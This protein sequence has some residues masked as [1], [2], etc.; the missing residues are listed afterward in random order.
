[1]IVVIFNGILQFLLFSSYFNRVQCFLHNR[2]LK[3]LPFTR[4]STILGTN[5]EDTRDSWYSKDAKSLGFSI[6]SVE[7]YENIEGKLRGIRAMSSISENDIIVTV[8]AHLALETTNNRPPSP[9]PDFV[10]Q[11]LWEKSKW[12]QRLAFMLLFEI[13]GKASNSESKFWIDKL[14]TA[15]STPFYWNQ[16]IL[17]ELHY[18]PIVNKVVDQRNQWKVLYDTWKQSSKGGIE[19]SYSEFVWALEC[20]NSRAFSGTYEGSSASERRSLF[21]FTGLLTLIWPVLHLGSPEQA[22]SAAVSVGVSI[23]V[24]DFFLSKVLN[25]K[26][27]VFC[28]FIDMFNH[29]SNSR[30]DVSYNYFQNHFE[31]RSQQYQQGDQV[32]ISYG[33][34]SND[35]LLQYYGFVEQDNPNDVYDFGISIIE[36]IFKY[37]DEIKT[38]G[39]I[40]PESPSPSDRLRVLADC[41]SSIAIRQQNQALR[42]QSNSFGVSNDDFGEIEITES[43]KIEKEIGQEKT[44]EGG[45]PITMA[46]SADK[47]TSKIIRNRMPT[48][49]ELVSQNRIISM[50]DDISVR[51]LRGFFA[52]PS[53][54]EKISSFSSGG[55]VMTALRET[56]SKDDECRLAEALKCIADIEKNKLP[57]SLSEDK[58]L[59]ADA[60]AKQASPRDSSSSVG[61]IKDNKGFSKASRNQAEAAVEGNTGTG[62]DPS[63]AFKNSLATAISFRIEKKNILEEAITAYYA[64]K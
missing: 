58:A 42:P 46:V 15:F 3:P 53:D 4:D 31:V 2:V 26:R 45:G 61:S 29:N 25:L 28:P 16:D 13:K 8:P 37:A 36:L 6:S 54:W 1:M 19:V 55:E 51:I 41:L 27:Y 38:Q 40:L 47:L 11:K 9:F 33:K 63:G 5:N 62:W 52:S 22:I 7:V 59:L 56:F 39:I 17:K 57:T 23:V 24:R 44:S 32:F 60:K 12:D 48:G 49:A 18:Q 14:P 30:S 34:Q 35:R 20:I 10:S 21:L 64:S 43:D 50:F